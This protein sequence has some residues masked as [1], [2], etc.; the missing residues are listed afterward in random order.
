[1]TER[2]AI[3]ERYERRATTFA[4]LIAVAPADR[5]SSPSPCAEWTAADVAQHAVDM[6]AA[7]FGP[8]GRSLS[9]APTVADNPLGAFNSARSDVE[10]ALG[11]ATI[12]D[13]DVQTPMGPS[14][15]ARHVDAV[16]SADLVIHGWDLA[17]SL[18]VEHA[19]DP[20]E[21]ASFWPGVQQT[22]DIM[23][24]PGAFGPGVVVYGPV[25][26]VPSDAPIQ[27]RMLGLL[28]RDPYWEV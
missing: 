5:W 25:V 2:Q 1:M 21:V 23:R 20:E 14:T 26:D 10:T 16:V 12:A 6:H 4:T 22:P 9:P 7:M 3:R 28:G 15:F 19:I 18:G 8:I 27:D 17:R 13:L 11:D 24:Q